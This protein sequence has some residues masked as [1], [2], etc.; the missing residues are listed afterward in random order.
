MASSKK[1]NQKKNNSVSSKGYSQKSAPQQPVRNALGRGLSA[2]IRP[3]AV[4]VSA[5]PAS[6]STEEKIQTASAY[7][8]EVEPALVEM[9]NTVLKQAQ[10]EE[11]EVAVATP[12]TTFVPQIISASS[13]A[14]D[15][16]DYDR[17]G[18]INLPLAKIY[19]NVNQPRRYFAE[20]EIT[21]LAQSIK[22]TG[23]L[24]PILVR[25]KGNDGKG[26]Y[27][28]VAG[29]RRFRAAT[30]AGLSQVPVLVRDL[31]DQES[32][33][34]GIVENVQ[35]S[36]LNPIEEA[37]A[38]QRLIED[39]G[40]TQSEVAGAVGKD[41][42]S[43]ANCLRLLKLPKEI[44]GFLVEKK[45]SAGHGRAILMLE[46][47]EQQKALAQRILKEGISVREAER[48]AQKK[49]DHV[50]APVAQANAPL[51]ADKSFA[52]MDV[53]DRLR[54]ALGTKVVLH[55]NAAVDGEVRISF[56]SKDELENLLE[57]LEA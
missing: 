49:L 19:P 53:E 39:F 6:V 18:L 8:Q 26:E 34:V 10:A 36:D 43:I 42:V 57:R 27:E 29:E 47:L 33:Q 11:V 7:T 38:Y 13:V 54:R 51:K 12:S 17:Q 46:K 32:L 3:A 28:I 52:I 31:T 55:V 44:Q 41:R 16:T 56:L 40:Q 14:T 9:G 35:R 5:K 1:L 23:L 20:D 25:R 4:S 24:Q 30:L 50:A 21:S 37:L 48:L 22:E 45:L 15:E 2:L